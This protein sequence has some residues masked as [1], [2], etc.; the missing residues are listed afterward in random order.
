M[1]EPVC[2]SDE[3]RISKLVADSGGVGR[4]DAGIGEK[5]ARSCSKTS[6]IPDDGRAGASTGMTMSYRIPGIFTVDPTAR[7]R[8]GM[9]FGARLI[10]WPL[11]LLTLVML[12]LALGAWKKE[13]KIIGP[14]A[15]E[16]NPAGHSLILAVPQESRAAW[17]RQPLIGDNNEKPYES[18]LELQIDG[19]NIGPAHSLHETIRE[20]ATGRFSHWGTNV[21]FSLPPDVKNAPDTTATLRYSIR[22]R[23]WVTFALA[24]SSAL[25][26]RLVYDGALRS[27]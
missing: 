26:G 7:I 25:F 16:N 6:G 5:N 20:S 17:W 4:P 11:A 24:I 10:F 19:R 14:F 18:I 9:L 1:A 27:L 3:R 8:R 2:V 12:A 22:P 23:A 13:F 15:E 21:I